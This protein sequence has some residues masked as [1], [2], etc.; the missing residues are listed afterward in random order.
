M[1]TFFL[2]TETKLK[3]AALRQGPVPRWQSIDGSGIVRPALLL[4]AGETAETAPVRLDGFRRLLLRYGAGS[5]ALSAD[6]ATVTIEL[7]DDRAQA[8]LLAEFVVARGPAGIAPREAILDLAAYAGASYRLRVGCR[9]GPQHDPVGDW[10]AIYE[11]AVAGEDALPNVRARAFGA[12]RTAN[13]IAHFK[14][15]Y[16]HAMYQPAQSRIGSTVMSEPRTLASLL[17]QSPSGTAELSEVPEIAAIPGPHSFDPPIA[18]AYTYAHRVLGNLLPARAPSFHVRMRE[19]ADAG[20][21]RVLS[22][23]A[24]AARIEAELASVAGDRAQWTLFDLSEDLLRTAAGN[25]PTDI[26]PQLIAGNLNEIRDFGARYDVIMCV[27]GLHHIVELERVFAFMRTAL[28]DNGEFWS[29]GEAIGRNGNRL[30]DR[31]Y[32]AAN[33]FFAGLPERFRRN[34]HSG[35]VDA[36]L[37]NVDCSEATFE[38]IRS[39]DIEPLLARYLTP[40]HVYR[41]NCF[42]WR[43]VDL[44]YSDN[45]DLTRQEDLD[46]VKAAIRAEMAHFASGGRATELHGI[47]RKPV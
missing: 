16:E 4:I 24:G 32:D 36:N 2:S 31:D 1:D 25:F 28:T 37:P 39:E 33:L 34:R 41:R 22:L 20:P 8:Q 45:Y 7:I 44:A 42:L 46:W 30:H 12:E 27:S 23:C 35:H 21:V 29:I 3:I 18:D 47:F 17:A 26:V 9:P 13:E 43:I 11:L 15:V 40:A 6:G 19:L 14:H 5:P 38:G 10:V